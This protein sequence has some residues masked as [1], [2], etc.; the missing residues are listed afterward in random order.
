MICDQEALK[1]A[2]LNH[3][4]LKCRLIVGSWR[5]FDKEEAYTQHTNNV[6]LR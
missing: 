6:M 4:I 1:T 5:L 2:A 3:P